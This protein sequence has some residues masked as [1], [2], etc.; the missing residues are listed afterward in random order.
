MNQTMRRLLSGSAAIAAIGL[1]APL[2]AQES[3]DAKFLMDAIRD[4]MAEVKIGGLAEMHG[5]TD[6]TRDYGKMLA[7]DHSKALQKHSALAKQKR[8]AVPTDVTAEQKQAYDKLAKESGSSFDR[9]FAQAMVMDHQKA[10]AA[11]EKETKG[12]RDKDIVDLA[13]DTLPTL[14]EH[15]EH[16]Q[17]LAGNEIRTSQRPDTSGAPHRVE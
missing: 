5:S 8:I 4:N 1:M 14:E 12:G 13:K 17:R 7:N 10:I 15:L 6:A 11:Y 9:E 3:G 2:A 16:A